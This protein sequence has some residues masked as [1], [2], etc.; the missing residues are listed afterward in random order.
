M[1]V[2][3]IGE[4]YRIV[5]RGTGVNEDMEPIMEWRDKDATGGVR[6]KDIEDLGRGARS[7]PLALHILEIPGGPVKDIES[8]VVNAA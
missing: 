2:I 4:R 1:R 3:E 8:F 5:Y 7:K 6:W